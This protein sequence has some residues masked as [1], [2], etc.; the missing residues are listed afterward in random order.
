MIGNNCV[1]AVYLPLYSK[2]KRSTRITDELKNATTL[3]G[4][5]ALS[6]RKNYTLTTRPP[7]P[8]PPAAVCGRRSPALFGG[9]LNQI[10]PDGAEL[11]SGGE[12][13]DSR[14][15]AFLFHVL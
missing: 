13:E 8:H 11:P 12:E 9:K 6:D 7:S 15:V 14:Y 1:R 4:G 2:N 5:V 3:H 10:A